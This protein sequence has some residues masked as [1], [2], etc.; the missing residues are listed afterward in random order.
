MF[1][2]LARLA[3][4]AAMFAPTFSMGATFYVD[5][6][7]GNDSWTGRQQ[8]P[9]GAPATDGPWRTLQRVASAALIPGDKVLLRCSQTWFE[10]L[11]INGSGVAGNPIVIGGYPAPC[12]IKPV[13]EGATT[14]PA[15]AWSSLGNS[16]YR[17]AFPANLI[18]NGSLE[19]TLTYWNMYSP[20]TNATLA[21]DTIC[22]V[23][24]GMC[25]AITSGNGTRNSIAASNTLRL[26]ATRR[27]A[28]SMYLK[29]P[30]AAKVRIVMR[31]ST[32]PYQSVGFDTVITGTGAWVRYPFDFRATETLDNARLD[33]E[34]PPGSVKVGFDEVRL[35]ERIG[36][37]S[38]VFEGSNLL[39]P[40]HHPNRGY[41][42]AQPES[43]YLL[44]ASNSDRV[45]QDGTPHS[46]YVVTG[47]DLALPIGATITSGTSIRL[48]SL[49]WTLEERKITS[50]S[51]NRLILDAPTR[52]PVSAG[53]GYFLT[54]LPWMV[55]SPGEWH[56]DANANEL[57]VRMF[58]NANPGTR[59]QVGQ[60]FSGVVL[61][62]RAFVTLDG[63]AVRNA[64]NGIE[65]KSS[66]GIIIRNCEI[67]DIEKL[68]IDASGAIAPRIESNTILRT[69]GDAISGVSAD[70]VIARQMVA[71]GN[72]IAESGVRLSGG[73]PT[74]MPTPSVAAIHSGWDATITNNVIAGTGH[75]GIY[76]LGTSTIQ[77]NYIQDGCLILDDCGGIYLNRDASN[78]Q[79]V[80]NLILR[81]PGSIDGK[82]VPRSHAVGIYLDDRTTGN[83]VR[84]NT[85]SEADWGIQLHNV[86]NSTVD[87]NT[88]YGNRRQ[89]I[90]LQEDSSVLRASGDV[91]G[92]S[93]SGNHMFPIGTDTSVLHET[94]LTGTSAFATYD[95]NAYSAL[96]APNNAVERWATGSAAFQFESWQ[97]AVDANGIPRNLDP[98]GSKV[99]APGYAAFR[100]AGT[101]IVPNGNFAAGIGTW[102]TWS[103]AQPAPTLSISTSTPGQTLN[104]TAGGG[105]ESILISPNF[106][107]AKDT[108]YRVSFD[109]KAGSDNQG[110]NTVVRRGGGGSNG[111]EG[112][113]GNSTQTVTANRTW[114][115]YTF[116]FKASATV[117]ANDPVTLDNGARLDFQ[118]ILPGQSVAVANVE[119]IPIQQAEAAL[120]TRLLANPYLADRAVDCPDASTKPALCSLYY[121]FPDKT[122]VLW[123]TNLAP[124]ATRV[125]FSI[126]TSLSDADNDGVPDAQDACPGSLGGSATNARGCTLAQGN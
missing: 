13:V 55:D 78:T 68:G 7:L 35:V 49:D 65:M 31:K 50:V 26:D 88:L 93:V 12:A 102:K 33:I 63:I 109:L 44:T 38:Q 74:G 2:F 62:N 91:F 16:V 79:I 47:S 100:I 126:D 28:L 90:W 41:R 71:T 106:S 61:N 67:S 48:R 97:A 75:N 76:P 6:S 83:T 86:S 8:A 89:Q 87:S 40:A 73:K 14:V 57:R 29:A 84:G 39:D 3:L 52:Y 105:T 46:T 43:I 17:A 124:L 92:N 122:Q 34:A 111:Y 120:Q 96:F 123:P 23:S 19:G 119:I 103:Q 56:F 95:R 45:V 66:N 69:G 4:I 9:I 42:A 72:N 21:L 113:M 114:S 59:I 25:G 64:A 22:P 58:D 36:T 27:Y 116:I 85:I 107:V 15:H 121:T 101:N 80:G 54:G 37:P 20:D 99:S 60:S 5:L 115:R 1:K 118:R 11:T 53:Y 104:F 30:V 112:L 70:W 110:V 32:S 108:W 82:P 94:T 98:N 117:N 10:S 81:L 51:G 77:N 24:T 18:R 125:I